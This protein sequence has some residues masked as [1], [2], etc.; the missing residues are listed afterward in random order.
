MLQRH[1]ELDPN[2]R[3]RTEIF[4]EEY[5][6][7]ESYVESWRRYIRTRVTH[8]DF[9]KNRDEFYSQMRPYYVWRE[10]HEFELPW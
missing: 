5:P 6:A 9:V 7:I 4:D 2:G 1:D 10:T 3:Q 8:P